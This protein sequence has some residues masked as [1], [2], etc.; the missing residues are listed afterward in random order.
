MNSNKCTL[1]TSGFQRCLMAFLLVGILALTGCSTNSTS[2]VT[3]AQQNKPDSSIEIETSQGIQTITPTVVTYEPETF[4]DPLEFI[5]RPIFKFNDKLY[6][7]ILIP[8]SQVY[9]QYVPDPVQ[10]GVG[11]FFVN[12]REPIN[13]VNHL[14]QGEGSK[15]GVCLARFVIN[16]TI[17][18]FGIFD[19]ATAWFNLQE[20]RSTFSDTMRFYNIGY[21][22]YLVLP[23]FGQS[24]FRNAFSTL[25]ESLVNPVHWISDNP[26]TFYLQSLDSLNQFAPTAP[27]YEELYDQAED[28]YVFF[29]NL[30]LQSVERDQDF[31]EGAQQI[32][33]TTKTETSDGK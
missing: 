30:Y 33:P 16:S 31:P 17:G 26:E 27:S 7:Y 25:G 14:A 6:R 8:A 23:I 22:N 24:D 1:A 32:A 18:L 3:I 28:P 21:G 15:F 4:E 29:R 20:E 11:N 2:N 10:T 13:M 12:L 5:N 19:P 9:T